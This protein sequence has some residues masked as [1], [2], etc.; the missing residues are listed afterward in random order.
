MEK[1]KLDF[2]EAAQT[3]ETRLNAHQPELYPREGVIPAAVMILITQRGQT[4]HILFTRRSEDVEHHKGQIS[5]P[6]GSREL[7]DSSLL[8]TALRETQEEIGVAPRTVRV[9]GR[10]DDFVTITDFLIS[11]FVG[12]LENPQPY[13]LSPVE[14][15]EVIEVPLDFFLNDL[16]FEVKKWEN[17][18]RFYDVYFYHYEGQII[19]GATAFMLN[20]F[21]ELA[22]GYNPAPDPV[23]RD[24]RNEHYLQENRQRQAKE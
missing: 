3:I 5:F 4:P 15:S 6:G 8:E 7:Q 17:N 21:I 12:V 13:R 9:L 23:Y 19:W 10:L 22:F 2:I 20:R 14:V 11:P 1:I 18:G 16:N 24:P